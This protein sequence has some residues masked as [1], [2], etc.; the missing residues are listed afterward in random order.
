MMDVLI[1]LAYFCIPW[2]IAV[3]LAKTTQW[4]RLNTLMENLEL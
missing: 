1:L 2:A 3:L 4:P